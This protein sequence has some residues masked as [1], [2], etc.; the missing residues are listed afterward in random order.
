MSS[1]NDKSPLNQGARSFE[2]EGGRLTVK[3]HWADQPFDELCAVASRLNAK[4]PFIFVSKVLGK[5]WP[6]QPQAMTWTHEALAAKLGPLPGPVLFLAM[7]ETAIGLGRGV[8]E[9]WL[10]LTGEEAALFSHTTRYN[11]GRP[12]ALKI[13]EPHSHARDHLVYEPEGEAAQRIFRE[14]Q[15]LVLVDDEIS[16]GRTLFNLALAY[17][18]RNQGFK[19][20]ALVCLTNWLSEEGRVNFLAQAPWKP[21]E[22]ARFVSLL[23]GEFEFEAQG[24]PSPPAPLTRSVGDWALKEELVINR[25]RLGL[26][27]A[28]ARALTQKAQRAAEAEARALGPGPVRVVGSGEFLHEPFVLARTLEKMGFATIFQST[29]R[30]PLAFEGPIKGKWNFLD[31]YGEGLDNFLYNADLDYPGQTFLALEMGSLPTLSGMLGARDIQL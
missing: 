23:A 17:S 18:Q 13:D 5:H 25:G 3:I 15:S 21:R 26:R 29:T 4:R 19:K 10:D 12:V 14:A 6:C 22:S 16:T 9:S 30:T 11:L 31:N 7:A 27:P 8:Y 24:P 28:Q 2:L 20:L 1:P